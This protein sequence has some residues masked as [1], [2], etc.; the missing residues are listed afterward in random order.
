MENQ[1]WFKQL[2]PMIVDL[3]EEE[4]EIFMHLV[5]NKSRKELNNDTRHTQILI[6]NDC[7]DDFK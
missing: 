5:K 3:D 7:S 4:I 6:D 2:M 1:E